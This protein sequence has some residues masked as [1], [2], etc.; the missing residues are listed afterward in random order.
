MQPKSIVL[1]SASGGGPIAINTIFSEMPRLPASF[2]IIQQMPKYINESF[3]KHL[4]QMTSMIVKTAED[5]EWLQDSTIYVAPSEKHITLQNNGKI[6]LSEGEKVHWVC[7]SMDV[8]LKS[9]KP[10]P[11]LKFISVILTGLGQDGAAGVVHLKS[12]NGI[13]IVQSQESCAIYGMPKFALETQKV[14]YVLAP[15][16][17]QSRLISLLEQD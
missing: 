3:C 13:N 16:Q 9:L 15:H 8:L 17:I 2:I 5:D 4:D 11:Q 6:V 10:E 7:P 1:I 12:L 14:D